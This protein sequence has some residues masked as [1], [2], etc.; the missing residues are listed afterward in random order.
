MSRLRL[1]PLIDIVRTDDPSIIAD[2]AKDDRLDR[3][4]VVRGPLFNAF[5]I[6]RLR[7]VLQ[8]GGKPLPT[9]APRDDADRQRRQRELETRLAAMVDVLS[10]G[11]H[12]LDQLAG[13]VRGGGPRT[14]PG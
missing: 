1:P 6:G 10:A 8:D 14:G 13:F 12:D 7:R 5:L 3:R 2:L 11:P 9:A 4:Y